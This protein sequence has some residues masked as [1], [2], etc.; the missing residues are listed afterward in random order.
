[1]KGQ[2]ELELKTLVSREEFER[3]TARYQ[4]LNFVRQVNTYF[5]TN[6][7]SHYAFRIRERDGEF[8]FTLKYYVNGQTVEYEKVFS[9]RFFDDPD[10]RETLKAFRIEPPFQILGSLT[11]DRAVYEN[12]LAELCFDINH[13][14]GQTDYEIEYEVKSPHDHLKT[15]KDILASE[16]IAYEKSWGSKYKRCLYSKTR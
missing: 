7:L 5:V 15:F 8:L 6:D 16:N 2:V 4:P 1:M 14:N 11:T 3:I 10:I 13:Y 12:E 9:G